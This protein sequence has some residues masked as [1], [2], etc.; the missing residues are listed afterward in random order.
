[1]SVKS[2]STS[3]TMVHQHHSDRGYQVLFWCCMTVCLPLVLLARVIG[4]R[5]E[6]WSA[7]SSSRKT[8]LLRD[9]RRM[10]STISAYVYTV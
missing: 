8:S 6:S 2:N 3:M 7:Q 5:S 1:M 10:A 9:A 4:W